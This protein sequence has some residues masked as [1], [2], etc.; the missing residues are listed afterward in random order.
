VLLRGSKCSA[1]LKR[2]F[3]VVSTSSRAA[4]YAADVYCKVVPFVTPGIT[5]IFPESIQQSLLI[6]NGCC[7]AFTQGCASDALTVH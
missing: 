4:A 5:L 1:G 7:D 6:G 2:S 3:V